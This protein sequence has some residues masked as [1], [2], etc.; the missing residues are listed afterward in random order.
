[1]ARD[2]PHLGRFEM[3]RA[4]RASYIPFGVRKLTFKLKRR[5]PVG[6]NSAHCVLKSAMRALVVVCL[7]FS[8]AGSIHAEQFDRVVLDAGHGGKDQGARGPSGLL[9][10]T[11]VLDIS[12][13][14]A[15]HLRKKGIEVT[16]TRSDDHY[17]KLRKRTQISEPGEG[18][19]FCFDSCQRRPSERCPRG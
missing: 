10:K 11:V 9:E 14:L 6:R 19:S 5:Q 12:K 13:R 17:V 7:G 16:L 3:D 2:C 1:M 8:V 15:N 18:R 4:V